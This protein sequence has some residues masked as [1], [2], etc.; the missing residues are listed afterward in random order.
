METRIIAGK[1]A[2][3]EEIARGGMGVI[4]R[5]EHVGLKRKVAIKA[6]HPQYSQEPA[7]VRRFQREARAMARL[8]HPNIIRVFDVG[9][10]QGYSYLEMEF[11]SGK[12]LKQLILE[13]GKLP[14]EETLHIALQIAQGLEYAHAHGIIHRDIKP[15]NIL[16][17]A[18][19]SVKIAD[20]GIAAARDEVSLTATG[21]VM[22]TP[23]Y[24]S[25]EQ[26]RGELVDA[27][28]DL[29]ATGMVIYHM[30]TGTTPFQGLSAVAI[31]GSLVTAQGEL[32]LHLS[33]DI[34]PKLAE[35]V[36]T[37]LNRDPEKR[38]QSAQAAAEELWEVSR[39]LA[40]RTASTEEAESSPTEPIDLELSELFRPKLA[41]PPKKKLPWPILLLLFI[42]LAALGIVFA[43]YLMHPQWSAKREFAEAK[44]LRD[45]LSRA[46]TGNGEGASSGK[47][48]TGTR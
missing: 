41:P 7:F 46:R 17:A 35:I 40:R 48:R 25:P 36:R 19:G 23:E 5:A 34:P 38:I 15:G 22:G 33:A 13:K 42:G 1:Y 11:F 12:D 6:L 39:E 9:E 3:E 27:P 37:L 4:Y 21:Q 43:I 2:I 31:I 45:E 20:F 32:E 16:V 24:M 14:V 10:D 47:R 8:D 44:A 30:L 29:Y 26:S 28:S 18:D